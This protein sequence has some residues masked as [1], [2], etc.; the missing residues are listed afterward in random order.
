LCSCYCLLVDNPNLLDSDL[1]AAVSETSSGCAPI[2]HLRNGHSADTRCSSK[3]DDECQNL[4]RTA[5]YKVLCGH[6]E[7]SRSIMKTMT[8]YDRFK[9]L[10]NALK[11]CRHFSQCSLSGLSNTH[12]AHVVPLCSNL[13]STRPLPII[14][15]MDSPENLLVQVVHVGG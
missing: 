15:S 7:L 10:G 13:S 11:Y 8:G 12:P 14:F 1:S 6:Q 3:M 9:I 2:R 5:A 4:V